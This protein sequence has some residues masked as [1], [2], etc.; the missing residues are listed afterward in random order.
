MFPSEDVRRAI[1]YAPNWG[2]LPLDA[3][4]PA[5]SNSWRYI[6]IAGRAFCWC[7][8][9]AVATGV[10]MISRATICGVITI[11]PDSSIDKNQHLIYG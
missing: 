6:T 5:S 1:R 11:F 8:D 9:G 7:R 3:L 10:V 4:A 2:K